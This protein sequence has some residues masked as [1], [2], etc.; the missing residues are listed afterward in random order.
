MLMIHIIIC[1]VFDLICWGTVFV[2]PVVRARTVF[3]GFDSFRCLPR[4]H[5]AHVR[6]RVHAHGRYGVSWMCKERPS[7]A[8]CLW[9]EV[10]LP[11]KPKTHNV[12][13]IMGKSRNDQFFFGRNDQNEWSIQKNIAVLPVAKLF[14]FYILLK[15]G[16]KK[17]WQLWH[18]WLQT[19]KAVMTKKWSRLFDQKKM[20]L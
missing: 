20:G 16:R 11:G 3:A 6:H 2:F 12:L 9:T 15:K 8:V 18:K 4:F 13:V 17:P 19:I 10:W 7:D 5:S 14:F 1:I